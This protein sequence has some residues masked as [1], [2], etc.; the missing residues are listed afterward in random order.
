MSKMKSWKELEFDEKLSYVV[1]FGV[2]PF[3]LFVASLCWYFLTPSPRT[4]QIDDGQDLIAAYT[5]ERY[6]ALFAAFA[7]V[8]VITAIILQSLELRLQRKELE[9]T[10][11]ELRGQR[12]MLARQAKTMSRERFDRTLQNLTDILILSIER[13]RILGE[14]SDDIGETHGATFTGGDA[15][16]Y[17]TGRV[18]ARSSKSKPNLDTTLEKFKTQPLGI[19]SEFTQPLQVLSEILGLIDHHFGIVRTPQSFLARGR[20]LS[21]VFCQLHPA[22]TIYIFLYIQELDHYSDK[23]IATEQAS[24]LKTHNVFR[25]I[26]EVKYVPGSL[27]EEA[28]KVADTQEKQSEDYIQFASGK[29]DAP[30]P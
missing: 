17:F 7:F 13:T 15:F 22:F 12:V 19:M 3:L 24:L 5:I 14:V 25:F 9:Q 29:Q 16:A 28:R 20:Y 23:Y 8:G 26:R 6:N 4:I 21:R 30:T 11:R 27:A 2:L 1:L 18:Y 10:R